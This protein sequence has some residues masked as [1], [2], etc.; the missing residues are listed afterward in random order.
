MLWT[1]IRTGV[2]VAGMLFAQVAISQTIL[3]GYLKKGLDSNLALRQQSFDLQKAQLDLKRARTLFYPQANFSSQYTLANGG[4]PRIF[5][6]ETCS[7]MY[8]PH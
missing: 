8:T 1:F 3:E 2:L 6:S 4:A 7:I 5:P